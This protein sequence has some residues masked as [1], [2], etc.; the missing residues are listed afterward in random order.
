MIQFA[1]EGYETVS[2]QL[3]AKVNVGILVLD[4]LGGLLV[5][6]IVDAATGDWTTL[7]EDACSVE[8]SEE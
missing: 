1:K 7:Q 2:C 5:P 4:I 6:V 3:N 8:L